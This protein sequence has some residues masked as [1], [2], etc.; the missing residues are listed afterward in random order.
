MGLG[1]VLFLLEHL[2]T[3]SQ[4]ALYFGNEGSG[5]ITLI[6]GIYNIPGL[7]AV[8]VALIG[9]P[10]LVHMIW[11][12]KYALTSRPNSFSND[13]SR[14]ALPQYRRNRAYT[15]QRITSW[16]LLVGIILH[17][18]QM[19]FIESPATAQLGSEKYYMIELSLD[20]G[21]YPLAVRQDV[22]LY[23]AAAINEQRG[24]VAQHLAEH[25]QLL[26]SIERL[27]ELVR[28]RGATPNAPFSESF[29][30][31][32]SQAVNIGQL[33]LWV[34]ALEAHSL[35]EGEVLAVST[36]PGVV[37][38]LKIRD[39][40]KSVWMR[41]LYTIFV[42]AACFHAFNGLWTALI[43]WGALLSSR[44]QTQMALVAKGMFVLLSLMGLA[45]IWAT[46]LS[47]LTLY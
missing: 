30:E 23:D 42:I 35:D 44:A 26:P 25:P 29:L 28:Q 11:G 43:T 36:Q 39:T 46:Y 24:F 14:P 31:V 38:L 15:L 21:L 7:V 5:F 40:F 47:E 4:A 45:A 34:Q 22:Q 41:I 6:N 16:I 20:S 37:W 1:L 18:A 9:V 10:L 33:Q 13:G 3:N 19:R 2:F 27:K 32:V 17:V 8:E 12:I